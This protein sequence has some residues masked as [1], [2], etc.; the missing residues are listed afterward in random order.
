[1]KKLLVF[2]FVSMFMCTSAVALAEDTKVSV[3]IKAWQNSWEEKDDVSGVTTDFGSALMLGP[4]V[5]VKFSNNVFL[6]LSYMKSMSDYESTDMVLIGD[7]IA[8]D[9]TD[10]DFVAGYMFNPYFG[11][12]IGYKSIKGDVNYTYTPLGINNEKLATHE[13]TGPGIGIIGNYPFNETVALYGSLALMKMDWEFTFA[14][15]SP[16]NTDKVTGA[17]LEIGLAFAL[18]KNFSANVGYKSQSFSG[19]DVTDTFS[20]VTFGATYSF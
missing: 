7:K 16:S 3:A 19:D 13:L 10:V 11:A 5:N 14:D 15:G 9:R 1:M 6:G 20:G 2:L 4:A 8:I 17:A 12:F 18:S